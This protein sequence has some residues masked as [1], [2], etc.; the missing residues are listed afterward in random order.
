MQKW[1]NCRRKDRRR[2]RLEASALNSAHLLTTRRYLRMLKFDRWLTASTLGAF[3][4]TATASASAQ[5][6][7]ADLKTLEKGQ[8]TAYVE[9][10]LN[11]SSDKIRMTPPPNGMTIDR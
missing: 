5:E 7:S 9:F 3:L 1:R 2:E 10:H 8:S 6:F 4:L 11:F